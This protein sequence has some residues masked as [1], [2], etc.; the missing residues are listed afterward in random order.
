MTYW[1]T[2]VQLTSAGLPTSRQRKHRDEV[3][4]YERDQ[5]FVGVVTNFHNEIGVTY[6]WYL[7]DTLF[8]RASLHTLIRINEP[9]T[10]FCQV[11]YGDLPLTSNKVEVKEQKIQKQS[12]EG[13]SNIPS[14][15]RRSLLTEDQKCERYRM[16]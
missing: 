4:G 8:L 9:G 1:T 13:P 10:Y 6:E 7:N 3:H 2:I 15:S 5:L 11:L 16:V 12:A 14:T